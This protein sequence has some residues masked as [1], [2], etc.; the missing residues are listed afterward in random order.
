MPLVRIYCVHC[1]DLIYD[2]VELPDYPCPTCD[3]ISEDDTEDN[4]EDDTEDD[5]EDEDEDED[6]TEDK[7]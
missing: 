4:T 7:K 6:E 5:T 1:G 2:D 3:E